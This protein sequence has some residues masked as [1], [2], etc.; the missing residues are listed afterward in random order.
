[1][2]FQYSQYTSFSDKQN[3]SEHQEHNQHTAQTCKGKNKTKLSSCN[4]LRTPSACPLVYAS[5]H[6]SIMNLGFQTYM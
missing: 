1:M 2:T 4:Q 6:A 3:T 5:I